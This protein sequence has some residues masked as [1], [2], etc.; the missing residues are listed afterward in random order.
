MVT[1]VTPRTSLLEFLSANNI[2]QKENFL[3]DVMN[4]ALLIINSNSD[5]DI[6]SLKEAIYQYMTTTILPLY[7]KA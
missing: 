3:K 2:E 5:N 1:G 7:G 4:W 6:Q